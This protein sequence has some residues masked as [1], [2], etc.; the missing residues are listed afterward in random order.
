MITS[1]PRSYRRGVTDDARPRPEVTVRDPSQPG[2]PADLLIGGPERPRPDPAVRRRRWRAAAAAVLV[3]LVALASA[4]LLDHRQRAAEERRLAQLVD[5]TL[6]PGRD[7]QGAAGPTPP[8]V[9]LQEHVPVRN[10][11]PRPVTVVAAHA[12]DFTLP[13]D[14]VIQP[15]RIEVVVLRSTVDCR[16][17]EQAQPA[18]DHELRLVLQTGAGRQEVQLAMQQPTSVEPALRLCGLLPPDRLV[19][20]LPVDPGQLRGRELVLTVELRS[21][22]PRELRVFG[23]EPGP[24][25]TAALRDEDG[26]PLSLP[27][28]LPSVWDDMVTV[29]LQLVLTVDDCEG[30]GIRTG[31]ER[32]TVGVRLGDGDRSSTLAAGYPLESLFS[33]LAAAC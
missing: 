23:L 24:G 1:V 5:L 14:I 6:V 8:L 22:S 10:D 19:E 2:R 27:Y 12:A 28:A 3:A 13:G 33:F 32:G 26:A 11:G 25:L 31:T 9:V 20:L 18:P 7:S 17:L 30:V 21:E 16:Q 29:R 15:G 4:E